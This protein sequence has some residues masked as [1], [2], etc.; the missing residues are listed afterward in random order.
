MKKV[1]V[2][3]PRLGPEISLVD[4]HCHLD[5]DAYADNLDGV[6]HSATACGVRRI[7]TV[8]IDVDSSL[9]AVA[10]AGRFPNVWATVGIHPHHAAAAGPEDIERIARLAQNRTSKVVAYGEIG[11]D[12]AKNYAPRD[13]QLRAFAM[14]LDVARGLGIPVIIHDRDAHEATLEV[15]KENAPYPAGGVMHCFSGDSRL[16]G[17]VIEL[18]FSVSIPGIVTFNRSDTLQQ[19]ARDIPLDHMLLETDGPFLAPVPFRG[20][21]NRPEYLLYTARKIAELRGIPLDEVARRTTRNAEKLF[22]LGKENISP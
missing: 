2:S 22:R 14:Q 10:L 17:R 1:T 20:K 21:I 4:T 9:A 5:M 12:Y 13:V 15:L 7:I 19:V 8:G 6:I 11:L 16:A 3:L 18:G